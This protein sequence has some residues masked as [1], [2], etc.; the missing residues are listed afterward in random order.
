MPLGIFSVGKKNKAIDKQY[1]NAKKA[2]KEGKKEKKK[3]YKYDVE[4]LQIAKKNAYANLD[5]QDASNQQAY[6]YEVAKQKFVFAMENKAYKKSLEQALKAGEFANLA[7]QHANLQQDRYTFEQELAL[8]LQENELAL[9]Y[10]FAAAGLALD[11][12]KAKDAAVSD[13]RKTGLQS[14][15]ATGQAAARGQAGRSAYK[16]QQAILAETAAVEN[17]IVRNLFNANLGID[18]DLSQL[19]DQLIADKTAISLSRDSLKVSDKL[20]RMTFKRDKLQ[21]LLN[22]QAS[23]MLKPEMGPPIPKPFKLP[24]PIFQDV[25]KPDFSIGKP[26]LSMFGQKQS[27]G[28]ALMGDL[29]KVGGAVLAGVTAGATAGVGGAGLSA[30]AG[31][32]GIFGM[33][34]TTAAGVGA[35]LSSFMSSY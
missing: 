34:Q 11:K 8:D 32:S 2:W 26:K 21:A 18:L 31:S 6:N 23:I 30:A 19:S 1:K 16:N 28:S 5:Y 20:A 7:F 22:A 3:Q 15:K 25:Y 13:L 10:K 14:I 33:S 4:S 24:K 35:G 27:F 17:E 9:N 29:F 12:R